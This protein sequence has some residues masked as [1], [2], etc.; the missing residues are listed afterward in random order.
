MSN[1]DIMAM[2]AEIAMFG[3]CR[4][5]N[6]YDVENKYISIKIRSNNKQTKFLMLDAGKKIYLSDHKT[7]NNRKMP[8]SFV[9]KLRKHLENKRIIYI[10]QINYDRVIDFAFGYTDIQYHLIVEFYASG[11]IIFTD[12]NYKILSLSHMH[13]YQDA[14]QEKTF[15]KTNEIYPSHKSTMD[16]SAYDITPE[17]FMEWFD[18]FE[19][20]D[21]TQYSFK[22]LFTMSPLVIFGKEY[23]EHSL[24]EL[25][26]DP[27]SQFDHNELGKIMDQVKQ[28]H[29]LHESSQGFVIYENNKAD[30][31]MPILFN[32]F[33]SKQN[34]IYDSFSRAI[35]EYHK[36]ISGGGINKITGKKENGKEKNVDKED[37]KL[38]NIQGQ[39][40][41]MKKKYDD[42]LDKAVIF[43]EN[44]QIIAN[45]L[46]Y[47][48]YMF[49]NDTIENLKKLNEHISTLSEDFMIDRIAYEN[50]NKLSVKT[51]KIYISY[52]STKEQPLGES[53]KFVYSCS[54]DMTAYE[55]VSQL[56]KM[57]KELETKMNSTHK[58]LEES[59][60]K[61]KPKK[62]QVKRQEVK[63]ESEQGIPVIIKKR[64]VY[65][66]EQYHWFIS[67]EG[68]LVVI[69]KSADQN[70]DL[71]KRH[72]EKTDLYIHSDARGSGSGLI[73]K[74]NREIPIR[75][76]D[77]A[78][79]FLIC[80]TASWKNG[81]PERPFWVFPEQV[82]KTPETGEYLTKG[83][84]IIRDKKNILPIPRLELG[85]TIMFKNKGED[86][87]TN[88]CGKE[89]EFAI[90]MCAPYKVVN[91]NKFK[92][93][94]IPGTGKIDKTIKKSI[95]SRFNKLMN[96]YE[97]EFIKNIPFDE[98][99]R[100][101][102]SGI[103]IL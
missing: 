7:E 17:K 28:N 83:S 61:M 102:M 31:F 22:K 11:N 44:H 35:E 16:S 85:L 99:Q 62:S 10:K 100:N 96:K 81:S 77:E 39:I 55:H 65:W 26:I 53:R 21:K 98:Y 90:P 41:R 56:Y 4:V 36:E 48:K 45:I 20:K 87:P 43:E 84:F 91:S 82:S 30:S 57:C 75:T 8:S 69:G 38:M 78:G 60:Q 52:N 18:N 63:E 92:V 5:Q 13:V 94:I 70:E 42:N 67:S 80:H 37:R 58:L 6:I 74:G 54:L 24:L 66:Y 33:K 25:N 103:R 97:G 101:L 40:D 3:D 51:R 88:K 9:M 50:T 49:T 19:D 1:Y 71:V 79:T 76:L 89:T 86:L 34:K 64:K 15:V 46:D 32:Q 59:Q 93:K 68:I 95:L 47:L 73:K 2:I 12:E 23:L 14:N 29:T 72:M 27:K